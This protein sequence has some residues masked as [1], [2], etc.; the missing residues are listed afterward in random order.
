LRGIIAMSIKL[1][2]LKTG[3]KLI[4]D[5]KELISDEKLCG[6]LFENPLK[7]SMVEPITLSSQDE[8]DINDDG[9]TV[10]ISPWIELTTDTKIPV[11]SDSVIAIVEP[12]ESLKNLYMEKVNGTNGNSSEVSFTEE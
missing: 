2:L 12:L 1:V 4:T 5:A 7:V 3:E 8:V 11:Y 9:I 10:S 6:Y